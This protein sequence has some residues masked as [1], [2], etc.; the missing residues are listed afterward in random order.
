MNENKIKPSGSNFK[1]REKVKLDNTKKKNEE[2][3]KKKISEL[4]VLF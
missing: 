1:N 3:L 4:I 2:E